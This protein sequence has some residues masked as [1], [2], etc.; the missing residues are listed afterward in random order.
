MT[1][2]LATKKLHGR[3]GLPSPAINPAVLPR[4]HARGFCLTVLH[5][6]LPALGHKH[7]SVYRDFLFLS[8]SSLTLPLARGSL[9]SLSWLQ[10]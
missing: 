4:T 9:T 5:P 1:L 6:G 7:T 3:N 8:A 2:V 10:P